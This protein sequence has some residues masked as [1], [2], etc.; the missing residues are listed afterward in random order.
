MATK[1]LS[2]VD[3]SKCADLMWKILKYAK[4]RMAADDFHSLLLALKHLE[5]ESKYNV[6]SVASKIAH[7]CRLN[8]GT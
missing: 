8:P 6:E 2:S 3:Q 5:S 4:S 1:N 7:S